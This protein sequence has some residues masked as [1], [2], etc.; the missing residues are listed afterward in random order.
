MHTPSH[1][2]MFLFCLCFWALLMIEVKCSFFPFRRWMCYFWN[3][4]AHNTVLQN[5]GSK[6][7]IKIWEPLTWVHGTCKLSRASIWGCCGAHLGL[8]HVSSFR[9]SIQHSMT[10]EVESTRFPE[11]ENKLRTRWQYEDD[12]V[13]R[14]V[15]TVKGQDGPMP[16]CPK[17]DSAPSRCIL[18]CGD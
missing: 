7:K 11:D 4:I 13:K 14:C 15:T 10:M 3:Y 17:L 16:E 2:L 12:V 6:Q 9:S 8:T 1:N 18:T 5:G